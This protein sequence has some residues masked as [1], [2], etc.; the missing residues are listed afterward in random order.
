MCGG[1]GVGRRFGGDGRD[2]RGRPW[3]PASSCAARLTA[4]VPAGA[5]R[6]ARHRQERGQGNQGSNA[7]CTTSLVNYCLHLPPASASHQ[8]PLGAL[9][10]RLAVSCVAAEQA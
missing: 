5:G 7:L 1:P 3:L 9:P 6:G 8:P 10:R 2:R 4:C